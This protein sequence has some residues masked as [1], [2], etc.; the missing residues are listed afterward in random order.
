MKYKV[1]LW[2]L[3]GTL[4]DTLQDLRDAGFA[5]VQSTVV[6]EAVWAENPY[7]LIPAAGDLQRFC[8]IEAVK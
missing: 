3:D 4:L 1:I 5:K 6:A 7:D 2:D 8:V